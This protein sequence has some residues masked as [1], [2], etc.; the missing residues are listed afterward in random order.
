VLPVEGPPGFAG[1]FG[2]MLRDPAP[3]PASKLA[4]AA[5]ASAELVV[6]FTFLILKKNGL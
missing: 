4:I 5:K 6:R 2:T 3:Q 1:R